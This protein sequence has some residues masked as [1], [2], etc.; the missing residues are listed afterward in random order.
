MT[1]PPCSYLLARRC[2]APSLNRIGLVEISNQSKTTVAKVLITPTHMS[3][4][5]SL[6][7]RDSLERAPRPMIVSDRDLYR[8][9]NLEIR[10]KNRA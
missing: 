3:S 8:S 7:V 4:H 6:M 5:H 10:G 1:N 9:P 2:A